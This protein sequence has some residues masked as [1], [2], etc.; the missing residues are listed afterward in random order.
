MA[1]R[2]GRVIL[3]KGIKLD[4]QYK[5]IVDYTESQMVTLCT[6]NNYF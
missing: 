3:S 4:R 5:N 2:T 1:D 6:N